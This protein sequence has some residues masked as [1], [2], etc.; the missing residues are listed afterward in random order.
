[1]LGFYYFFP[2]GKPLAID[3]S[4]I[5]KPCF[6]EMSYP[7]ITIVFAPLCPLHGILQ[8]FSQHFIAKPS[9]SFSQNIL[10]LKQWFNSCLRNMFL[11]VALWC[12]H[13][14]PGSLTPQ[15]C[16]FHYKENWM[17]QVTGSW[18]RHATTTK[19]NPQSDQQHHF[20]L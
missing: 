2:L 9:C 17:T 10:R 19:N 3:P 20:R 4:S 7:F 15:V 16:V 6:R 13:L 14:I 8:Q 5:S 18:H 12:F 11:P 1:M